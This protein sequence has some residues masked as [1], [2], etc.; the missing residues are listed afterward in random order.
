MNKIILS[1]LIL[2]FSVN[3]YATIP[4][5]YDSLFSWINQIATDISAINTKLQNYHDDWASLPAGVKSGIK[6]RAINKID[7]AIQRLTD[8]KTDIN[9]L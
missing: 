5:G 1:I 8:V 6:T 3:A 2:V 7:E 4:P 9:A